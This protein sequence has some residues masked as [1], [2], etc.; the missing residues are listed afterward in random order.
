MYLETVRR[1]GSLLPRRCRQ[2]A[3]RYRSGALLPTRR[4]TVPTQ[5]VNKAL[6]AEE[7]LSAAAQRPSQVKHVA[8]AYNDSTW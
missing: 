6:E 2:S 8:L 7:T 3:L 4:I 5:K 1:A